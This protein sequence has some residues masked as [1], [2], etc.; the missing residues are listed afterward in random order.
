MNGV[1]LAKRK[2][3]A[4]YPGS[5]YHPTA[6]ERDLVA[7][8]AGLGVTQQEIARDWIRP[9][10]ST[11]TLRKRFKEELAHAEQWTATHLK[12]K[13]YRAAVNGSVRALIY[14]LERF[15]W[16]YLPPAPPPRVPAIGGTTDDGPGVVIIIPNGRG[17]RRT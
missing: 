15:Y 13:L 2:S 11:K 16:M 5:D 1:V 10:I 14:L 6:D 7:R 12:T 3:G 17:S 8:L 4:D 9:S